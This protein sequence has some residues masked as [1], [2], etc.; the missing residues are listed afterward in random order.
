MLFACNRLGVTRIRA[1]EMGREGPLRQRGPHRR[2]HQRHVV[3]ASSDGKRWM[4][5]RKKTIQKKRKTCT[6]NERPRVAFHYCCCNPL[7]LAYN[8]APS[9]TGVIAF[10]H[11]WASPVLISMFM[12]KQALDSFYS[13]IVTTELIFVVGCIQSPIYIFFLT[14][15]GQLE[16]PTQSRRSLT[17][18][19]SKLSLGHPFNG[20]ITRERRERPK[21]H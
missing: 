17:T 5:T 4:T 20:G 21:P 10:L 6:C 15:P 18:A 8:I 2:R 16:A 13:S 19:S 9:C 14:I 11:H 3:I 12:Q 1:A 7:V